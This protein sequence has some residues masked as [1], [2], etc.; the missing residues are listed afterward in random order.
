[1]SASEPKW[2]LLPLRFTCCSCPSK[3]QPRASSSS[4]FLPEPSPWALNKLGLWWGQNRFIPKGRCST[5]K[6]RDVGESTAQVK[7]A[8]KLCGS[9][10]KVPDCR[11]WVQVG[12]QQ[13]GISVDLCLPPGLSLVPSFSILFCRRPGQQ[14]QQASTSVGTDQGKPIAVCQG[15]G[16][17]VAWGQGG[18]VGGLR[19]GGS[20]LQRGV[21]MEATSVKLSFP[22]S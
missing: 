22:A 5:K 6:K 21:A 1:M 15:S 8:V 18:C 20:G 2:T 17:R 7:G 12:Q 9:C 16:A 4:S 14:C 13:A 10:R 11:I 3:P 19:E